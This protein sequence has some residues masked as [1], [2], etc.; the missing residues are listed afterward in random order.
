M[1]Y[2]VCAP[3]THPSFIDACLNDA[4]NSWFIFYAGTAPVL[5]IV[6]SLVNITLQLVSDLKPVY[7]IIF[8]P[9]MLLAWLL[10]IASWGLCELTSSFFDVRGFC[11]QW[12]VDVPADYDAGKTMALMVIGAAGVML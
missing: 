7:A 4:S 8:S 2:C 1:E 5:S 3:P 12:W 9:I 10:Q 6:L 11:Y